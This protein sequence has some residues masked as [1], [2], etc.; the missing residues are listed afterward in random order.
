MKRCCVIYL[1]KLAVIA[2]A[3]AAVS[4]AAAPVARAE[5]GD[6]VVVGRPLAAH[7]TGSD[8][9]FQFI[10]LSIRTGHSPM[11]GQRRPCMGPNCSERSP[12]TPATPAMAQSGATQWAYLAPTEAPFADEFD[13]SLYPFDLFPSE[14]PVSSIEHPPRS[15]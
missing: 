12:A 8:S 13:S 6:Y 2:S 3:V 4:S 1:V 15:L 10:G 5:C 11:D 7:Q 14:P 9:R